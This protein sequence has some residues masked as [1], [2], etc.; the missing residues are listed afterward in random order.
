MWTF[1]PRSFSVFVFLAI[2]LAL[3][4]TPTAA[5]EL[6]A[7]PQRHHSARQ[8]RCNLH[9]VIVGVS[10]WRIGDLY[11]RL[12]DR[13]TARSVTTTDSACS[14]TTSGS[15]SPSVTTSN[16]GPRCNVGPELPCIP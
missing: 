7:T 10:Q 13:R 12:H 11:H 6:C 9:G 5:G 15:C 1:L 14:V 16:C 2:S 4:T 8:R 3:L